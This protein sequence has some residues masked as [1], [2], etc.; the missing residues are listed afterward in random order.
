MLESLD[1]IITSKHKIINTK[2]YFK[3]KII[4]VTKD[5]FFSGKN[6]NKESEMI[7]FAL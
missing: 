7:F 1:S 5:I 4:K 3:G 6:A 2:T